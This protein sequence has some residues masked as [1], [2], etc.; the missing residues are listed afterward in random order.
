MAYELTY[1]T[2]DATTCRVV[3]YAGT[4]IDVV[5]PETFEGRTVAGL[6]GRVFQSCST[7]QSIT[8]PNTVTDIG[9]GCFM[10]CTSLT[11]VV[12]PQ[13]IANLG[14]ELF[15]GCT[16][17]VEIAIPESVTT[18]GNSCFSACSALV[19]ITIPES[20]TEIGGACF[21]GCD[22]LHKLIIPISV[23]SIGVYCFAFCPSL[24]TVHFLGNCPSFGSDCFLETPATAYISRSASGWPTPPNVLSGT[25]VSTAYFNTVTFDAQGG[26]GDF[27]FYK[28]ILPDEPIYG[29][30]PTSPTRD[31]YYFAGFYTGT[32]GTGTPV[33][34]VSPLVTAADHT[35]YA[36]WI[37]FLSGKIGCAGCLL[38]LFVLGAGTDFFC[39]QVASRIS[40]A[41]EQPILRSIPAK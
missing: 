9:D 12:F 33:T 20:V 39:E 7:L 18:I 31:G 25:S 30:F 19:E 3:G 40:N 35:L 28:Y 41:V 11:Q 14:T 16:S 1:E 27:P 38:S 22:S 36:R 13:S 29:L 6:F 32:D 37:P 21:V 5:I 15:Y 23:E 10:F 8:I 24:F 34:D 4:P 17:L 26:A 2:I